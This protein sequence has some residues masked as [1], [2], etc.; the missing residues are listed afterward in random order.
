M[1][2]IYVLLH[3]M[4]QYS[5]EN[6][7]KD[8]I[9]TILNNFVSKHNLEI[10]KNKDENEDTNESKDTDDK[11]SFKFIGFGEI[12]IDNVNLIDDIT[13]DEEIKTF[14]E[15]L[16]DNVNLIYDIIINNNNISNIVSTRKPNK[17]IRYWLNKIHF[18]KKHINESNL[19]FYQSGYGYGSPLMNTKLMHESILSNNAKLFKNIMTGN[20]D[21]P[22]PFTCDIIKYGH[23]NQDWIDIFERWECCMEYPYTG[24]SDIVAR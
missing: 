16:I 17:Y 1:Q 18:N 2:I 6:I 20:I 4:V 19:K 5:N 24:V 22:I 10:N 7:N 11:K 12:L 8:T 23:N 14:G 13:E 3:N 21:S 15:N 9:N